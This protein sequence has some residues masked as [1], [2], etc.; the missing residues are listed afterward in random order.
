MP[1]VIITHAQGQQESQGN[2]DSGIGDSGTKR[3]LNEFESVQSVA[4]L[5]PD[6]EAVRKHK[7][8]G[9]GDS[10]IKDSGIQKYTNTG[11]VYAN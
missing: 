7:N 3:D 6:N 9:I 5:L 1:F 4:N 11:E 8:K 10:V 2:Q